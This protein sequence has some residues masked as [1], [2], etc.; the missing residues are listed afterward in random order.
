MQALARAER[1]SRQPSARARPQGRRS[2]AVFTDVVILDR[3]VDWPANL[4]ELSRQ[5]E[6]L[7]PSPQL[8]TTVP[9]RPTMLPAGVKPR[10]MR[11]KV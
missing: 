4:S 6:R 5:A 1:P 2:D 3:F 10:A 7:E 11:K 8:E 9:A